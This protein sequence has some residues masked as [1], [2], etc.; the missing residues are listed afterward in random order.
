MK[1]IWC[2]CALQNEH[3]LSADLG[4]SYKIYNM[5]ADM[6]TFLRHNSEKGCKTNITERSSDRYQTREKKKV[7]LFYS[8]RMTD[9]S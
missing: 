9:D 1:Y 3:D 5:R 2:H 4:D 6:A 7:F 8:L